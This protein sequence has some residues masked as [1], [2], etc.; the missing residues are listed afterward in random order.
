M[1]NPVASPSPDPFDLAALRLD[2]SATAGPSVKKLLTVV[3]CRKPNK[4]EFFR[5]RPGESWQLTTAVLEDESGTSRDT[6][7]LSPTLRDEISLAKPV[8]LRVCV[9]RQNAPFLW[10]LKLPGPDGR[11]NYWNDSALAAAQAA[12]TDWVRM[13]SDQAAGLYRTYV[14]VGSLSEPAWPEQSLQ[15]LLKL[16]FKGHYIDTLEHPVLQRLRGEI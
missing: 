1:S 4:A 15:E 5:V 3:P 13:E 12:E 16:A 9:N 10:P 2:P 11:S 14:A 8:T 6:Y 7:L